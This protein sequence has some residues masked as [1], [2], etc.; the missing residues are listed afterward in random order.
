MSDDSNLTKLQEENVSTAIKK[1]YKTEKIVNWDLDFTNWKIK[2]LYKDTLWVKLLDEPE[3]DAIV[4]NGIAIPVSS[5]S[6]GLYRLAQVIK[7]GPDTVHAKEGHII[8]FSK[9]L[10]MPYEQKV[11]NYKTWLIREDAIIAVVEYDG[12]DEEMMQHIENNFLI[13]M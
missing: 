7:A 4:R 11:D 8:R 5:S 3:A 13:N 2:Q 10:G 1:L 12:T 6:Q 9:G